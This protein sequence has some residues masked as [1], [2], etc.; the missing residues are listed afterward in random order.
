[1]A[2]EDSNSNSNTNGVSALPVSVD[3]SMQQRYAELLEKRIAQLEALLNAD[4]KKL[5]DTIIDRD[6]DKSGVQQT[7]DS[8]ADKEN[9]NSNESKM[10]SEIYKAPKDQNKAADKEKTEDEKA[11]SRYRNI[12]RQWNKTT[13]AQEDVDLGEFKKRNNDGGI[14]FTFRR[15]M[16]PETG[17]KDAISEIDI[18]AEGLRDLLREQIGTDYPGQNLDGDTVEMGAPFASLVHSWEKLEAAATPNPDDLPNKKQA[19]EDLARLLDTVRAAPELEKY[20]K[21]RD[22]NLNAAITT[23]ETMWTLFPPKTKIVAKPFLNTLQVFEVEAAPIPYET[24]VPRTLSVLAWCWDWNGKEMSK[25]YYWLDIEKFRGTKGINL[26][27]CYP[28]KYH[29]DGTSEDEEELLK[30]LKMRGAKYNKIVRS[31]PGSTQM[32]SYKGAGVHI[33]GDKEPCWVGDLNESLDE[34][35]RLA[36]GLGKDPNED[37]FLLFPPRFLGYSTKEKMWGQFSVDQTS[38]VPGKQPSMFKNQLQLDEKYKSMIQ[39]LVNEHE[40]RGGDRSGDRTQVKDIVEDKGK[41]L[42]LL[43]HGPPG[44]GKTLTAETI[45]EATGRPLFIVSVAEIGLNASQAEKNLEQMFYLA[46]KWEAVLLV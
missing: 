17:I 8:K 26:L 11:K 20:F 33:L 12:V 24:P 31:G 44:V 5:P 23:Y 43:L 1:M 4:S 18:E 3:F 10:V 30:V 36:N 15:T 32:Y 25:V 42:V 40:G 38:D 9:G 7:N 28:I 27:P 16:D 21:T 37:A 39:A 34:A 2:A 41:G 14:A 13:G 46:G 22:S 19:R 6:G 35:R 29:K 45:A